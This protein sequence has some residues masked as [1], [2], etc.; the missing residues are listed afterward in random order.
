MTCLKLGCKKLQLVADFI[1]S[2]CPLSERIYFSF[3]EKILRKS[4]SFIRFTFD[5]SLSCAMIPLSPLECRLL[6]P[7]SKSPSANTPYS[8]L[9][10]VSKIRLVERVQK[11]EVR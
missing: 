5:L 6:H 1:E 2:S 4:W 9:P 7:R 8:Q 11:D 10:G 3:W